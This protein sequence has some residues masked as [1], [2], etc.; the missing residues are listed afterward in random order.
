MTGKLL[1]AP[2]PIYL[3]MPNLFARNPGQLL[4]PLRLGPSWL[5]L[6]RPGLS[7]RPSVASAQRLG[8]DWGPSWGH[9]GMSRDF[10]WLS[11]MVLGPSWAPQGPP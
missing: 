4:R 8:L 10:F 6:G 11:W 3:G 2:C 7:W 5:V 1:K 9:L